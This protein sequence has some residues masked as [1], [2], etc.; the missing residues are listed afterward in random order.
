VILTDV[1]ILE[2]WP[3]GGHRIIVRGRAAV[4]GPMS[5]L[6]ADGSWEELTENRGAYNP[7]PT[8]YGILLPEGALDAIVAE[9]L[10]VAAPNQS[11]ERHLEDA[12]GVRD[13]LLALV[14]RDGA[15]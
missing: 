14:E 9:H 1:R 8:G 11:T 6:R 10:K 2:D 7:D 12:I 4:G 15:Q 13:R 5:V 3:T